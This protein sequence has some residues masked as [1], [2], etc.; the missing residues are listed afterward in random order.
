MEI[1][2]HQLLFRLEK[3]I[4]FYNKGQNIE[5]YWSPW[6]NDPRPLR[7]IMHGS[8]V[9]AG[10]AEFWMRMIQNKNSNLDSSYQFYLRL[11]QVKDGLKVLRSH[12]DYSPAG[13]D[14]HNK[15][16]QSL[17]GYNFEL[18]PNEIKKEVNKVLKR[19]RRK[20][21]NERYLGF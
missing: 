10:V 12:A 3:L 19:K 16:D 21:N 18:I 8:F 1:Y 6:R 11:K 15:V 13:K 4:N 17:D 5:S 7:M 14:L 9:F 2:L 20:I